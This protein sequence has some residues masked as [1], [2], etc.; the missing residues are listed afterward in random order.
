MATPVSYHSRREFLMSTTAGAMAISAISSTSGAEDSEGLELVDTHQHLWDLK[1]F[2]LPWLPKEGVLARSYTPED[3][4]KA[5]A[6]T[7]IKRSV[8]MEVDV[9]VE[10]QPDEAKY[11][12]DLCEQKKTPTVGAVISGR[13]GEEAFEKW[14]KQFQGSP[15][16]KGFRQVLNDAPS[17]FC[18]QPTFVKNIQRLSGLGLRF[19]ICM[20]AKELV[21]AVKLVKECPD[22]RFVVD[23][24]GNPDLNCFLPEGKRPKPALHAA[25]EWKRSIDQLAAAKNTICKISGVIAQVTPGWSAETLAPAVN[26]CLDAFGPDRVVFGSDWPVCLNGASLADWVTTLK[27]IVASRSKEHREKL[28]SR[29]A[30]AFYDLK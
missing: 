21:N 3:Y 19:D 12:I 26:H 13:P 5:I 14:S 29:N 4:G 30:V 11:L 6:G 22:T 15:W 10:Q 28:F 17:G 25:D 20:P 7:G 27:S 9:A 23:H 24:C 8:Y 18:I 16:I 1:L 2:R